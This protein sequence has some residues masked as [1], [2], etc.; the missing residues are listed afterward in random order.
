[1]NETSDAPKRS[2]RSVFLAALMGGLVVAAAGFIAIAAGW[3][4]KSETTVQSLTATTANASS[5]TGDQNLVNQIYERDSDGVGFITSS[6]ITTESNNPFDP[7]GQ[8]RAGAVEFERDDRVQSHSWELPRIGDD[9]ARARYR[10]PCGVADRQC[11]RAE[12]DAVAHDVALH[13]PVCGLVPSG[14]AHRDHQRVHQLHVRQICIEGADVVGC[15]RYLFTQ[16]EPGPAHP[17]R[18]TVSGVRP[19]RR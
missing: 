19:S 11:D 5:K 15:L 12:R 3:I 9:V 10:Q 4:G 6:G 8:Q 13:I 7:F 1:M 2:L 16:L 17:H 18:F 14:A